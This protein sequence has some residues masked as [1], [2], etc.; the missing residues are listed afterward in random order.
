MQTSAHKF[1]HWEIQTLQI[2]DYER[3]GTQLIKF[4]ILD[5]VA[6]I[7][8]NWQN[9]GQRKVKGVSIFPINIRAKEIA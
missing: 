1:T 3:Q 9:E 6:K 2:E 4:V 5:R 7:K 8:Q